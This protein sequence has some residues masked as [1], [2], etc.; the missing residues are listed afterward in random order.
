MA[1]LPTQQPPYNINIEVKKR[2][3]TEL[4]VLQ[5]NP[6]KLIPPQS[7]NYNVYI[8]VKIWHNISIGLFSYTLIL[9]SNGSLSVDF[10]KKFCYCSYQY[11]FFLWFMKYSKTF[12]AKP[13]LV[14]L[15]IINTPREPFNS[16]QSSA[17][18]NKKYSSL[19]FPMLLEEFLYLSD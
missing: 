15:L 1:Q 8:F 16:K 2:E 18:E 13:G 6:N 5:K 3:Y 14:V 10:S 19:Y 4:P 11:H 12:V 9:L 7:S 17:L